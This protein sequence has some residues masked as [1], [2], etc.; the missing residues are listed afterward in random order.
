MWECPIY[1]YFLS[2]QNQLYL[3]YHLVSG[4]G[5][6]DD[7]N[8]GGTDVGIMVGVAFA[9]VFFIVIISLCGIYCRKRY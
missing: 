1:V 6:N 5:T 8:G 7:E 2:T 4:D 3:N 9:S